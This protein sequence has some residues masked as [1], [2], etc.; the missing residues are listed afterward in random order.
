[1]PQVEPGQ[2]SAL[3]LG[4]G[5]AVLTPSRTNGVLNMLEAAKK[6]ARLLTEDLP[7]FPSLL[8]SANSIVPQGRF[9]EAQAEFLQPDPGQVAKL[10][11]VSG[12]G[13]CSA[14]T[15][16]HGATTVVAGLLC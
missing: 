3:S 12:R 9:A 11:Q 15:W 13:F 14:F 8:I 5:P 6:R 1:L 4:V 16:V 7:T 10:V 2:L